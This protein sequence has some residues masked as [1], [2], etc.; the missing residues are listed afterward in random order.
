MMVPGG[1]HQRDCQLHQP[2][3]AAN[4]HDQCHRSPGSLRLDQLNEAG[5]ENNVSDGHL[6]LQVGLANLQQLNLRQN[7]LTDITALASCTGLKNLDLSEK[8]INGYPAVA[9]QYRYWRHVT[10]QHRG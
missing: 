6:W 5:I 3:N 9:R 10:A 1:L 8:S 2:A 7:A 4:K